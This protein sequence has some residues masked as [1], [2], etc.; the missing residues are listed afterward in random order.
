VDL[1]SKRFDDA[2]MVHVAALLRENTATLTELNLYNNQI[3]DAGA[4][5][6]GMA[7]AVNSDAD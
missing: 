6:L 5:G 1:S 3:S 4:I 2:D 7:L